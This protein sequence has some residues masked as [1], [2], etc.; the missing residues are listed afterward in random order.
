M[1]KRSIQEINAGSMADIAFLLL[2]FFLVTTTMDTDTGLTRKLPPIH[3]ETP[4]D[5]HK[6]NTLVILV[7]RDNQIMMQNEGVALKDIRGLTKDFILNKFDNPDLPKRK[8]V[9]FD[10]IGNMVVTPN[11]VISL[12]SDRGTAYGTFISVQNELVGVYS[13]LKAEFAMKE[14]NMQYAD[15]AEKKKKVVDAVYPI[16]I[17]EAEP[18]H[19]ASV[20]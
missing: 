15:L 2:I 6:R 10:I 20:D 14:W 16:R 3:N 1:K 18:I 17:S 8:E 5:V 12:Q 13:D 4:P 11:H 7:N 19:I 9:Y